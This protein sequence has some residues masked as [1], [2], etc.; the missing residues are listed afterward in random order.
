MTNGSSEPQPQEARADTARQGAAISGWIC[1]ALGVLIMY[2]SVWTFVVYV[3][4]FFVAFVLSIVA[5]AQRR[6]IPGLVLLLAT[7]IVPLIEWF[8]LAATRTNKFL[9]TQITVLSSPTPRTYVNE[10]SSTKQSA[11]GQP[12]PVAGGEQSLRDQILRQPIEGKHAWQIQIAYRGFLAANPVSPPAYSPDG[13]SIIFAQRSGNSALVVIYR[14]RDHKLLKSWQPVAVPTTLAWSPDGERVAYKTE[15]GVRIVEIATGR[16]I[17]L[18]I[19]GFFGFPRDRFAWVPANKLVCPAGG[20][21]G[22]LTLDL[23]SLQV[24]Q[25]EGTQGSAAAAFASTRDHRLCI[26]FQS[27]V[28][29]EPFLFVGERDGSYS[30]VLLE[31]FFAQTPYFSSPDLRHIVISQ[32]NSFTHLMLGARPEPELNYQID[33]DLKEGSSCSNCAGP[34]KYLQLGVPFWGDVSSPSTNPLNGKLIGPDG[35]KFKGR[36]RVVKWENKIALVR[37]ALEIK[38][39]NEGDVVYNI[40]SE[41]WGQFGN[42]AWKFPG[43]WRVLNAKSSTA[44]AEPSASAV[45][46][47]PAFHLQQSRSD[48]VSESNLLGIWQGR[49]HTIT[50]LPDHTFKQNGLYLP[51]GMKWRLDGKKLTKFYPDLG[52]KIPAWY[53]GAG[54]LSATI[55]SL[56]GDK[57]VTEA[58]GYKFIEYRI[59]SDTPGEI[60]SAATRAKADQ[61]DLNGMNIPAPPRRPR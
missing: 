38:P 29:N 53:P 12:Q 47:P 17:A 48:S 59:K 32:D 7:I 6:I 37:T 24:T 15:S 27:Q 4:L 8:A 49:R 41:Q 5:M 57:L 30:H 46:K 50:F 21:Y 2:W 55:V 1:F 52:D 11:P 54:P 31:R 45:I 60:D 35:N 58:N 14:L 44:S 40:Q 33:L 36:I 25:S 28:G 18:P 3:P 9:D 43:I 42:W 26:V 34:E 22:T 13:E 23:D 56:T 39:I 51:E 16:D 19:N 20:G 61:D 10:S